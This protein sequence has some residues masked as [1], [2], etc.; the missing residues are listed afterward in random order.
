MDIVTALVNS[1]SFP[2]VSEQVEVIAI[3][4]GLNAFDEFSADVA[5]SKEF[6]LAYADCLK[7]IV[8]H[9]NVSEGGVSISISDRKS[10]IGLANGVYRKYSESLIQEERPTV[11]P[12]VD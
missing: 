12:I 3:R 4:R 1:V 9:P 2:L 6:E 5:T 8:T 7:L 11:Q 10:F